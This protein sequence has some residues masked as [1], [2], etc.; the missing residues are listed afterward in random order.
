MRTSQISQQAMFLENLWKEMDKLSFSKNKN[1]SKIAFQYSAD[2]YE[3]R[4]IVE[5]LVS[6]GFDIHTSEDYV[7][8]MSG[9]LDSEMSCEDC[10]EWGFEVE[11]QRTGELLSN[12]D[13]GEDVITATSEIQALEKAQTFID[14]YGMTIY[15]VTR[16]YE[17]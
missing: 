12:F 1:I 16:V 7:S 2:G 8:H 11:N 13:L 4:E 15:T 17:M 5:L 3:P 6:D 10:P 9:E 14:S